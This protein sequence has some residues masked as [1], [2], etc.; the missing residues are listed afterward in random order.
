VVTDRDV[1]M[2]DSTLLPNTA[3]TGLTGLRQVTL[4]PVRYL[5]TEGLEQYQ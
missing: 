2:F 1:L 3:R 4:K 5:A